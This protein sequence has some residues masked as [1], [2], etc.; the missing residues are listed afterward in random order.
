MA[1]STNLFAAFRALVPPA[2]LLLGQVVASSDGV[3]QVELLGGQMATVRG[4]GEPGGSV[5]V[6]AG[7]IEGQAPNLPFVSID[8]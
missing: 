3:S 7:A 1:T 2:P 5:W 6:R 8:I 4:A